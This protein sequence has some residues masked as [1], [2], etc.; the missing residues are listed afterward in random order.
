MTEKTSDPQSQEEEYAQ[1]AERLLERK[2][3]GLESAIAAL[4]A[5]GYRVTRK[6]NDTYSVRAPY[7][8]PREEPKEAE[9]DAREPRSAPPGFLADYPLMLTPRQVSE[10]TGQHVGSIRRLCEQG[11]LPFA[12]IG[13][14]IR[15]PRD[16]V[17]AM[18]HGGR[19][20]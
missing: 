6:A 15:I 10:I 7:V 3:L 14:R 16:E 17:Y 12:K 5:V 11:K 1:A 4:E 20:G 13:G 9:I 8:R 2:R 18:F 19:L